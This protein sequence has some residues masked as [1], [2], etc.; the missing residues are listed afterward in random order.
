MRPAPVI[1]TIPLTLSATSTIMMPRK[2]GTIPNSIGT[3]YWEYTYDGRGNL[4]SNDKYTRTTSGMAWQNEETY[5][6]DETNHMVDGKNE[7]G[8]RSLYTYN[9]L[10]LRVGRELIMQD[11]THGYTDFHDETP[12]VETGIDKPEVAVESYV[13]DYTSPTFRT[14]VMEEEGGFDYRW[15]G[16]QGDGSSVLTDSKEGDE[17]S[18]NDE[19]G[20]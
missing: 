17:I 10:G 15:V 12:S 9:G 2:C 11:N 4:V 5:V 8:E 19:I 14:L 1:P 13:I 7:Q 6:Y 16:R 3:S 18:A 20:K